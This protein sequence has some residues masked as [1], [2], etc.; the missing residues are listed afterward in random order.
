M[1]NLSKLKRERMLSFLQKL[2]ELHT[3]DESL[4]AIN[5]IEN[6]LKEKKYGLIWEEHSENVDDMMK[7]NIPVFNETECFNCL[8]DNNKD[9]NFLI[10]GDN[11]QALHL[12]R[13]TH[14]GKVDCI[15]IDPPYNTGENDF[16]Y[17][18]N[19][20]EKTDTYFHSKWLSFMF[21]RLKI[22]RD[23]LS[24]D[25]LIF[26][27]ID[28]NEQANLKI[29]CDEIFL[30]EN[31]VNCIAIKMSEATGVKMTHVNKKLPKLK[32][33]VLVYKKKN[34]N[35][36]KVSVPKEKWDDEY[37]LLIKNIT[38]EELE[39][40]KSV[41]YSETVDEDDIAKADEILKNVEFSNVSELFT[42]KMSEDEKNSIKYDNAW[43]IVRDVATTGGAKELAD[44]K[45]VTAG[46][47]FL[48][49][50]PK[51]KV[52]LIKNGYSMDAAQPR[53]KLL[54]ADNY[55][56]VH[57]G[58]FWQDIKTT[59]LENE[60]NVEF[61]NGKKPLK[62]EIRM[63]ELI[64][65]K[66]ATVLDFFAGS[67]TIGEAVSQLNNEDGGDRRFI[68]VTNNEVSFEKEVKFFVEK[69]LVSPMPKKKKKKEYERW[70]EEWKAFKQ[71]EDYFEL[72]KID[73][74]QAL[75]ICRSTTLKRLLYTN[76]LYRINFKYLK[77]GWIERYPTDNFLSKM[78]M[79]H[80]KEMIEIETAKPVDNVKTV[81][82]L[83]RSDL[84]G[85]LQ[86]PNIDKC[87]TIWINEKIL[88]RPQEMAIISKFT[89]RYV[90]KTYFGSELKEVAE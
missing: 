68:L 49:V 29:L 59:G 24:D 73:E 25:G 76:D 10:E 1:A 47:A 75:G 5:E 42:P 62:S 64:N 57:P 20:V 63:L 52:Y 22:A 41:L 89:Y 11:L 9:L 39:F 19:Y 66:H 37:K 15:I 30:E 12:L 71:S 27:H 58:D 16:A 70:C 54:F 8:S 28:D 31:F 45:R 87:E 82:L 48:I 14:F 7:S 69:G 38:E 23:L 17:D 34:I 50:T 21:R 46:N 78:L 65:N 53:I 26:I 36:K 32:E 84:I 67:G 86:S 33:Y 3:D 2:R 88:I 79:N 44:E 51:K 60:G 85:F 72:K 80:I 4:I 61:L 13:K 74:Y 55:L 18:D 81:L 6:H 90:P 40:V 43:R 83:S 35:L 56:T 77:C